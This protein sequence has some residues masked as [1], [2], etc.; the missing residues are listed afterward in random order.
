[1]QQKHRK[2]AAKNASKML[3]KYIKND[4]KMYKNALQMHKK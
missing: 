1:M 2:N 4:T 3:E